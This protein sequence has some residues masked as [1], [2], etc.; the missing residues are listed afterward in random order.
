MYTI[1]PTKLTAARLKKGTAQSCRLAN[2]ARTFF[3]LSWYDYTLYKYYIYSG[4][5][6]KMFDFEARVLIGW[7]VQSIVLIGWR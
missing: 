5:K 2:S 6:Q 1:V 4:E 7:L 3:N